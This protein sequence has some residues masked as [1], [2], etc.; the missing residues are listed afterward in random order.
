MTAKM[1]KAESVS[2]ATAPLV[3]EYTKANDIPPAWN[4]RP[5]AANDA[6]THIRGRPRRAHASLIQIF[7]P[8]F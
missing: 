4:G 8:F 7:H 1:R 5:G 2:G 3:W 6:F